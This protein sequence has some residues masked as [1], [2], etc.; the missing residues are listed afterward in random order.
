MTIIFT[1]F[2]ITSKVL[3]G[4]VLRKIDSTD[5]L[6]DS[7]DIV[8]EYEGFEKDDYN[9]IIKVNI[10][11]NTEFYASAYN[12]SLTFSGINSSYNTVQ[13]YNTVNNSPKFDGQF[14]YGE[15]FYDYSGYFAPGETREY[16]FNI[17]NSVNFNKEYF[18]TNRFNIRYTSQ[19]YKYQLNKNTV[20]KDV[21][22]K[23]AGEFLNNSKDPYIID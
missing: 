17:P 12:F 15:E 11:N 6:F 9:T 5:K 16:R 2:L 8:M 14:Y 18:D 20:F 13:S 7:Y 19:F 21:G 4:K 22:S 10:K 1:A 23:S 3:T